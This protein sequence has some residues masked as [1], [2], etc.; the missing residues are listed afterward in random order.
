MAD[1]LC[2]TLGN[3]EFLPEDVTIKQ[4]HKTVFNQLIEVSLNCEKARLF[5]LINENYTCFLSIKNK[6]LKSRII[7]YNFIKMK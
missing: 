7:W 2:R 5:F 3:Y 6:I 4:V 1:I